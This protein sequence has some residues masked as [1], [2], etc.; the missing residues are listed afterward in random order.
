MRTKMLSAALAAMLCLAGVGCRSRHRVPL[1]QTDEEA[2]TLAT[3]VHVADPKTTT[4]LVT[5]FYNV[6]QNAWRWTAGKFSVLLRPPRGAAKKGATLQFKFAIPDAVIARLKTI[7]LSA[8]VGGKSLSP[9]TYTQAGEFAYTRDVPADV[10]GGE[11]VKVNF[12]VDKPLPP[13]G[14]EQ[15]EL[16]VVATTVGFEAK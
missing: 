6:E 12:A 3:M 4:Q 2:P 8:T 13:G 10:L 5:G 11:A 14:G 16:G 9:E 7:S 1:Q 15:R